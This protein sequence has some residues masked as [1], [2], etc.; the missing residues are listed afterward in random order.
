MQLIDWIALGVILLTLVLGLLLGFG[1]VLKM[2]TSG[3]FGILISFVVTYFCLGVVASWGFVQDLMA[4]LLTAMQNANNGIVNFLID[5]G[6]EKIILAVAL[7][8]IVQILRIIIVNIIKSVVEV[9]NTVVKVINRILGVVLLFAIN[10]MI[11][12]LVFHIIGLIGGTTADNFRTTL[13]GSVFKLDWVFEHNP[14]MSIIH[15]VIPE[16]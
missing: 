16:A 1:K 12:L 9:D 4:K 15:K 6:I 2:F 8:I 10:C 14:L 3:I 13:S 7:F 11:V 5:I